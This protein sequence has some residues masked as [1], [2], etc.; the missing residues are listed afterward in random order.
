MK[1]ARQ[2]TLSE[3]LKDPVYRRWFAQVP[4]ELDRTRWRVYVKAKKKKPWQKRDFTAWPEAYRFVEKHWEQ[5]YDCVLICRND[6]Y[7]PPVIRM[8]GRRQYHTEVT[9][10]DGHIWCPYCRRPTVFG[11]FTE[12]HAFVTTK[13]VPWRKRCGICGI[14]LQAIKEY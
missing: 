11:Y 14:A 6:P 1:P 4:R 9:Q 8:N 10:M 12:H 2:V 7:R 3:L 5:W 13:P